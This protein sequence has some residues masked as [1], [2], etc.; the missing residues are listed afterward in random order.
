MKK[1]KIHQKAEEAS[2]E[3][4]RRW[5]ELKDVME[6]NQGIKEGNKVAGE[7]VKAVSEVDQFLVK[8]GMQKYS[9][10]MKENGFDDLETLAEVQECHLEEMGIVLGHRL[11]I[12]KKIR[13]LN[14]AA[15]CTES[16]P[17]SKPA[18]NIIKNNP[19]IKSP[20]LPKPHPQFSNKQIEKPPISQSEPKGILKNSSPIIPQKTLIEEKQSQSKPRT[21][22]EKS[23]KFIKTEEIFASFTDF[24]LNLKPK[25]AEKAENLIKPSETEKKSPEI[26]KNPTNITKTPA[27]NIK[28]PLEIV[29]NH[30]ETLIKSVKT[31]ETYTEPD[32]SVAF[33]HKPVLNNEK[34]V[35]LP[36][37]EKLQSP[38]LNEPVVQLAKP[39][40]ASKP[41]TVSK[42]L[43]LYQ[44]TSQELEK[45]IKLSELIPKANETLTNSDVKWDAFSYVPYKPSEEIRAI[46]N[47]NSSRPNS[48]KSE[49]KHEKSIKQEI[50]TNND[51][52]GWDS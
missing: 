48:A 8:I 29:K 30:S 50:K 27:S 39:P 25:T 23:S 24:P 7:E 35:L 26:Q 43:A 13:E 12:L 21:S 11:K 6:K 38:K 36:I 15:E 34:N 19:T 31:Q 42:N 4:E 28:T 51:M 52:V 47:K 14:E 33:T 3:R 44:P 46:S 16:I 9:G 10:L 49:I 17:A 18:P 22:S 41:V 1:I 32:H 2:K 45:N 40:I 37:T 5:K 20:T